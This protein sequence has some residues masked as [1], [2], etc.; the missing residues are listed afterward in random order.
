MG[1]CLACHNSPRDHVLRSPVKLVV[2]P[3]K[4]LSPPE[5][6]HGQITT[7]PENKVQMKAA[8]ITCAY[9]EEATSGNDNGIKQIR[10]LVIQQGLRDLLSNRMLVEEMLAGVHTG[11]NT[12]NSVDFVR[13]W[14]PLL[15]TIPEGSE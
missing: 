2:E 1:N 9:P 3:G 4:F 14:Q 7:S 12:C 5:T 11:G 13:R 10:L 6:D 8:A 15:E